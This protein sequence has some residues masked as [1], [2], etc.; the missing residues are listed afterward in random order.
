MTLARWLETHRYLEP[1]ARFQR[2]VEEAVAAAPAQAAG[3]PRWD[4]YAPELERG[5]P[6]LA[7]AA[8]GVDPVPA[9]AG[10]LGAA[11]ERL[12]QETLPE[13]MAAQLAAL[14]EHLG[15][16]PDEARRVVAWALAG[17]EPEGAPPGAGIAAFLSWMA[18][19]KVL[20]PIAEAF[21]A[22][23]GDRWVR[24]DCPTC[25]AQPAM[26][27]LV[28]VGDARERHLA[29]GRCGTSWRYRRI[30]CPHCPNEEADRLAALDAG[31]DGAPLRVDYCDACKGYVK[32]Y[33]GE[34]DEA[35][36]LADWSTLHLDALAAGRGLRRAGASLYVL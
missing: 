17:A 35:L 8:H 36:L 20:A 9:A 25:G 29:C 24:G 5:I 18:L 3:V 30:A 6:L 1:I 33:A 28:A 26:A 16:S 7:S 14:R 22:W 23:R 4:A 34:G 2:L 11:C 19:R 15:R 32:T 31:A 10:V 27:Q 13:A 21:A 12:G